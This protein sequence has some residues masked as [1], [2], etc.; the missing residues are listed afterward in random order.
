MKS[1]LLG[2]SMVVLATALAAPAAFAADNSGTTVEEII[3]TGT[4]TVGVKAANSAAPIQVVG[5]AALTKTGATDLAQALTSDVPSLNIQTTGGDIAAL[6]IEANLRGLSPNDTLVLINGKRLH[7]TAD[8]IIDT[9]SVYTGGSS[10]DLSF[11]PVGAIDHVEVLTDGAAA[12]YGTDAIAGVMNIILKKN[13]SGGQ[14]VGTGGQDYN[15]QGLTGSWSVNKGF[16]LGDRGYFNFTLE[17]RYHEST[18]TGFG[19]SRLQNANGTLTPLASSLPDSGEVGHTNWPHE[20]QLYGDPKFSIF[21]TEFN[22]AYDLGEGVEAYAFGTY[23]QRDARHYENDRL[24]DK[25]VGCTAT[26]VG[27]NALANAGG[28]GVFGVTYNVV[29]FPHGFDPQEGIVEQSLSFT[30]GVRGEANGFRWDL[31]TTYG[32]DHNDI[33][34]YN[35]ANAQ[36]YAEMNSGPGSITTQLQ[37]QTTFYN[38][39]FT[40]TQWTQNLDVNRDFNVGLASPLNVAGGLEYRKDTFAIAAGEPSSYFGAGAQSFDGYTPLDQ[41]DHS[42]TNYGAYLDFAVNPIAGLHTDIAGRYEHYSDFGSATVGKFTARYDFNPRIAIRGTISTGFRAPTLEEEFYSGTNVS[43]YSADVVLPPN[44]AAAAVAGFAPLKP[45]KST[46]YSIGFVAHPMDRMQITADFYEID[47]RDRILESGLIYGTSG[48]T[49]VSQGVLNAIAAK[50][51]TLD[52]GLSYAGIS[53][54][55]NAATTKTQG[56]EITLNYASDFDEFGH[57]DWTLGFNYNETTLQK[58]I[59][60]PAVVQN[61]TYPQISFLNKTAASALTTANP[62]EKGILQAN[63]SLGKWAVNLRETV[64]G[65]SAQWSADN[66]YYEQINTTAITD[67]D[68]SYKFSK[69]LKFDVGAN[70]LFDT[71]PPHPP[72]QPDKPVG[73]GRVYNVPYAFAPWGAN[74]GYYYGRFTF[75]F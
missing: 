64:Y 72:N 36:L 31:S 37:P 11:I 38:G 60:L 40:A 13:S 2:T 58:V 63:W 52:S 47:I 75:S 21:N 66:T 18:Y 12:Q 59:E 24:P 9:G 65:P 46:N 1:A 7:N 53:T 17:Q 54:F 27:C 39:A 32:R 45:E 8:L 29:P 69:H 44:S 14:I 41:G 4:R 74:G 33:Y 50:G 10:A 26:F 28:T 49:V 22:T 42:R 70:N 35:S 67:L 48:A 51:V 3:V 25:V 19:D 20:N 71:I 30:G 73:G 62:K 15:G 34:V 43:P 56:A 5:G 68:V 57:V 16:D 23:G 55:A 61:P 6:T